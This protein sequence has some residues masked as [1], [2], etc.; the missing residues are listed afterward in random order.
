MTTVIASLFF[1]ASAKQATNYLIVK[2]N[3]DISRL[4][5]MP[6]HWFSILRNLIIISE[7]PQ[8]GDLDSIHSTER[9]ESSG[10]AT[11]PIHQSPAVPQ[12]EMTA[13]Q[14]DLFQNSGLIHNV[15]S[16]QLLFYRGNPYQVPYQVKIAEEHVR[17]QQ[18][19]VVEWDLILNMLQGV[20]SNPKLKPNSDSSLESF[21]MGG[22]DC[23]QELDP[24]LIALAREY[25]CLSQKPHLSEIEA[26][27]MAQ[28][29][30][31]ALIDEQLSALINSMDYVVA[32]DRKGALGSE[33]SH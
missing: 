24:A 12:Q 20:K 8:Q 27:R 9:S 30:E 7:I 1:N 4:E 29:L 3:R 19:R 11:F 22:S 13:I 31:L 25:L 17:P 10:L 23:E 14:E 18:S 16:G 6:E 15:K 32:A 26:D 5:E 2:L 33:A 28:I 21:L